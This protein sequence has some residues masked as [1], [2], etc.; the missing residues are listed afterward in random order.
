MATRKRNLNSYADTDYSKSVGHY[1]YDGQI[2]KILV[3]F[4]AVFS[5]LQV[6]I[7]KNGFDSATNLITVPIKL[8]TADRVVAAIMAGNTQNKPIRLPAL[9]AQMTGMDLALDY[10]KGSNQVSRDTT[11]PVGGTLPDDGKVIYKYMPFPYWIDMELALIASNEY[12]HQQMLEQILLLFNPDLQ[13][14]ISDVYQDWTKITHIELTG[15]ETPYPSDTERRVITSN[16]QFRVLCYLSPAINVKDNYIKKIKLRIASMKFD[17]TFEEF[18]L[19]D[20]PGTP[21]EYVTIIDVDD[22]NIPPR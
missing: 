11:F 10:V 2:R 21:E 15:I 9:A 12:Q 5:E 7:G 19:D 14:Q 8:G 1:F 4:A 13:I 20:V 22:L 6:A 18:Q 3:Q 17:E 16:L